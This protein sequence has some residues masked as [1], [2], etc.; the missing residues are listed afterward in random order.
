MPAPL[1]PLEFCTKEGILDRKKMHRFGLAVK[2]SAPLRRALLLGRASLGC[3][4][5][6]QLR[7][8]AKDCM[9]RT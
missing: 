7:K 1:K 6:S 9:A 3:L 4:L 8:R 5:R 2:K